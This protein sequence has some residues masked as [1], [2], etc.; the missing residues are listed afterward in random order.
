MENQEI[1]AEGPIKPLLP[2][3]EVELMDTSSD[4]SIDIEQKIAGFRHTMA[5][6]IGKLPVPLMATLHT[7]MMQTEGLIHLVNTKRLEMME[8]VQTEE[9]KEAVHY[10]F[11]IDVLI[12]RAYGIADG[13]FSLRAELGEGASLQPIHDAA[14]ELAAVGLALANS[15]VTGMEVKDNPD[16]V[17]EPVTNP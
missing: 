11:N 3:Q 17:R 7:T 12:D 5:T 10:N 14:I 4:Q 6:Q 9:E 2:N 8:A 16:F 1:V 13:L 15:L